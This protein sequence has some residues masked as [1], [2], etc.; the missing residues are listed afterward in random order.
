MSTALAA[1]SNHSWKGLVARD[2]HIGKLE[3]LE[4]HE[5]LANSSIRCGVEV[6][7][8]EISKEFVEGF[9]TTLA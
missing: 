7:A 8:L 6:A 4:L 2:N 1:S 5:T 9:I 3:T